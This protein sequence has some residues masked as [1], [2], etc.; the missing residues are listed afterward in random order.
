MASRVEPS[1]PGS[2]F[3]PHLKRNREQVE[4]KAKAVQ[5]LARSL[6]KQKDET[7]RVATQ[8]LDEDEVVVIDDEVETTG[9][10]MAQAKNCQRT[11]QRLSEENA[12][13]I[14]DL[15]QR[16]GMRREQRN[17]EW[18]IKYPDSHK[19][20]RTLERQDVSTAV[21]DDVVLKGEVKEERK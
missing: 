11:L 10:L 17:L 18:T 8:E 1:A 15:S 14:G 16:S 13:L 5:T 3:T 19:A 6:F 20:R 12:R 4:E 21:K 2:P 9:Q 7:Q